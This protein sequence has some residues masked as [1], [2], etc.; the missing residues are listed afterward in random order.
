LIIQGFSSSFAWVPEHH[1]AFAVLTNGDPGG[2]Y[3]RSLVKCR[4]VEAFGGLSKL[5]WVEV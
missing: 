5:N 2:H 1:F 3:L 4:L